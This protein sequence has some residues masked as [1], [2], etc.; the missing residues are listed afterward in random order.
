MN[1]IL[2]CFISFISYYTMFVVLY[3]LVFYSIPFYCIVL[4][5]ESNRQRLGR[6]KG[7]LG[8]YIHVYIHISYFSMGSPL[9]P[10]IEFPNKES[11]FCF[12]NKSVVFLQIDA[13]VVFTRKIL[14][15]WDLS[16]KEVFHFK[17]TCTIFL[18]KQERQFSQQE[19]V[20]PNGLGKSSQLPHRISAFPLAIFVYSPK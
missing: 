14:E 11:F 2:R 6:S 20:W 5:W 17:Q 9:E 15:T 3:G 12:H 10:R 16:G 19:F 1:Y 4:Y 8:I 18:W 7:T 13:Q